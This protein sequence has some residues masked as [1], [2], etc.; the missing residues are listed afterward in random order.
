MLRAVLGGLKRFDFDLVVSGHGRAL[1]KPRVL[2][3]LR[4]RIVREIRARGTA[5][6]APDSRRG[7]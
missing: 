4:W 2:E 5:P 6:T 3:K 1:R 7:P